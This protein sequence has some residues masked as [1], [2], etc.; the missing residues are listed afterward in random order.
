MPDQLQDVDLPGHS[1]NISHVDYFLFFEYFDCHHLA[2]ED[3]GGSF[4]F[5]ESTFSQ[6]L[7]YLWQNEYPEHMRLWSSYEWGPII[8]LLAVVLAVRMSFLINIIIS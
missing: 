5:P 8:M 3:V 6:S 1:L 7:A 2:C 4:H